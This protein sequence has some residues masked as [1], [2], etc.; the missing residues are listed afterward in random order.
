MA[1]IPEPEEI[2]EEVLK[3]SLAVSVARALTSANKK[4][5]EY[6]MNVEKSLV[7]ITQEI[8]GS[9]DMLWC[10]HYGPKDYIGQRGGDLIVYVDP[11]DYTIRK[12]L[13]GQ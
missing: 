4:A 10:V 7:S 8:Q 12:V 9:R 5:E 1:V 2:T 6:E 13:Q 11:R 3:D